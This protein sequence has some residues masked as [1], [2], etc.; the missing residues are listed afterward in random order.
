MIYKMDFNFEIQQVLDY[1]DFIYND[2]N[3][4]CHEK[5]LQ[6]NG[7][8]KSIFFKVYTYSVILESVKI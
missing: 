1:W 8:L 5:L 2:P 4:E 7:G 6:R 3:N